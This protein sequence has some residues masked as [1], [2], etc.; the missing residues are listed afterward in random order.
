MSTDEDE[1]LTMEDLTDWQPDDG[2]CPKC[3]APTL[4]GN[5]FD[6]HPDNGGACIG[7]LHMCTQCDYFESR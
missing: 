3:S 7:T 2:K 5:W 1:D 4:I 6:D